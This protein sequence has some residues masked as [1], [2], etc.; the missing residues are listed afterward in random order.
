MDKICKRGFYIEKKASDNDNLKACVARLS[1]KATSLAL[2]CS[3]SKPLLDDLEKALDKLDLDADDS[4]SKITEGEVE[5]PLVSDDC[6]T[7]TE[8]DTISFKVPQV[9]KVVR[10]KG[11][12][13]VVEKNTRK[14][15]KSS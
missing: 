7:G 12:K 11:A 5:V 1:Q 8:N 13:S 2:K 15:K 6:S 14:K 4:L 9:V 10:S 3:L